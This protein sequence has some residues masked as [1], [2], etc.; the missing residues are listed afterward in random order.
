MLLVE[1]AGPELRGTEGLTAEEREHS[2]PA[3]TEVHGSCEKQDLQHSIACVNPYQT[4]Q[5]AETAS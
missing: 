4:H 1:S 5:P 2:I 3:L